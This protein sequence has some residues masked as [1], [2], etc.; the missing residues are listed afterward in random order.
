MT[1]HENL[2]DKMSLMDGRYVA[3]AE[4]ATLPSG[5][6]IRW[7]KAAAAVAA[8][9]VLGV[10]CLSLFPQVRTAAAEF[11]GGKVTLSDGNSFEG[12]MDFVEM[13]S[14]TYE[15]LTA[16][17]YTMDEVSELMGVPF[18]HTTLTTEKTVPTVT[19]WGWCDGGVVEV[20]DHFFYLYHETLIDPEKDEHVSGDGWFTH[21]DEDDH[22]CIRYN[23]LFLR[24]VG[25]I[26]PSFEAGHTNAAFVETYTTVSGLQAGIF[27]DSEYH[28]VIYR[29]NVMHTFEMTNAGSLE[30]FKAFLDTLY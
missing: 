27:R 25:D 8:A 12:K 10:G 3:E 26:E 7:R 21:I 28:A 29:D 2:L 9:L 6:G 13:N 18:L 19:I 14:L 4:E 17:Y 15:Q 23:A 20:E 1:N 5:K 24:D 11:F 30:N 16:T 22:Y